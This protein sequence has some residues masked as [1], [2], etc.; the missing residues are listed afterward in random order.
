MSKAIKNISDLKEVARKIAKRLK[1]GMI[2]NIGL[3]GPLGVGKTTF[4]QQLTK[5]LNCKTQ[6]SS[7]TFTLMHE[8]KCASNSLMHFDFYRI[9][10]ADNEVVELIMEEL[11]SK[12]WVIAEWSDKLPALKK[13]FDL[14]LKFDHGKNADERMI[15]E[16]KDGS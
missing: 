16:V 11:K 14:L 8:Y 6:A 15:T 1:S 5:S 3:A 9:L 12:K 2:K 7:P 10:S 13:E 4:V